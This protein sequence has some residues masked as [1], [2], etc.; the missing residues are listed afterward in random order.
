M[1][2][3]LYRKSEDLI[4]KITDPRRFR[5]SLKLFSLISY[6]IENYAKKTLQ[7]RWPLLTEQF[8]YP[9]PTSRRI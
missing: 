4:N 6:F 3:C 5:S 1:D 8:L 7:T 2:L 9:T